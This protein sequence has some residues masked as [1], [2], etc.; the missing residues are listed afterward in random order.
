MEGILEFEA[1]EA[2]GVFV[3]EVVHGWAAEF[4]TPVFMRRMREFV[5][6]KVP[7]AK[8]PLSVISC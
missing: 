8:A 6:G 1:A 2:A 5:L 7:G 4:A 3:P